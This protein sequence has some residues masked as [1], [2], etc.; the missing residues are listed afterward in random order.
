MNGFLFYIQY[1]FFGK[2]LNKEKKMLIK[3]ANVTK[4]KEQ[5]AKKK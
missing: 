5:N 4:E 2:E 3:S 1:I